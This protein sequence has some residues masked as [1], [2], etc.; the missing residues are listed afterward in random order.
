MLIYCLFSW[1]ITSG[2]ACVDEF[3]VYICKE[4]ECPP[5]FRSAGKVILYVCGENACPPPFRSAGKVILYSEGRR[6][7]QT[8]S[9]EVEKSF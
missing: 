9:G 6:S 5:A 4:E 1:P 8:P 2:L 7:V 3:I